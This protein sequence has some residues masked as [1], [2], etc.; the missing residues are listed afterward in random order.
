MSHQGKGAFLTRDATTAA[1]LADPVGAITELQE[2][3]ARLR[4]EV[5]DLRERVAALEGN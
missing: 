4:T 1:K 5:G 2:E 3:V